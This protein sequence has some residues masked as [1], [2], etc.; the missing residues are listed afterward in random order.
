[1]TFLDKS[2]TTE[3]NDVTSDTDDVTSDTAD[4]KKT[5]KIKKV[6]KVRRFRDKK[7]EIPL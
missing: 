1:M 5:T 3:A 6:I 4:V 2:S 7:G